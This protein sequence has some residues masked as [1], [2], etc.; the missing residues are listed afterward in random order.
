MTVLGGYEC[1]GCVS[2]AK[3]VK[4]VD[5][6]S[7]NQVARFIGSLPVEITVDAREQTGRNARLIRQE[8][9][10]VLAAVAEFKS[11]II[12]GVVCLVHVNMELAKTEGSFSGL[13]SGKHGWAIM[14]LEI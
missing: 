1:E 3:G 13:S 2:A 6:D 14:N 9:P 7:T 5:V 11:P 10:N 4:G 8:N 12:L